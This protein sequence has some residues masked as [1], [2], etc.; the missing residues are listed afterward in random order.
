MY[1]VIFK[2]DHSPSLTDIGEIKLCDS[3]CLSLIK[4]TFIK[5]D[6]NVLFFLAFIFEFYAIAAYGKHSLLCSLRLFIYLFTFLELIKILHM[7]KVGRE[8]IVISERYRINI[9][10][11]CAKLYFHVYYGNN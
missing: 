2:G 7:S 10:P 5:S 3:L 11:F 9:Q 8:I 4:C 1:L 6:N